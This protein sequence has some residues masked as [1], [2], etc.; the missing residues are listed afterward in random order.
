ME[1]LSLP[2]VLIEIQKDPTISADHKTNI[3]AILEKIVYQNI[4]NNLEDVNQ[5][6]HGSNQD[7]IL[8]KSI[9]S[10]NRPKIKLS[11]E[12]HI[13]VIVT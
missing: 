5:M 2:Q 6:L 12:V 8:F 4:R 11:V 9:Q 7:P 10:I 3:K 1:K 13:I